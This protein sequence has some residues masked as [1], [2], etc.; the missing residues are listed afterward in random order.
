MFARARSASPTFICH[1]T[2]STVVASTLL[3]SKVVLYFDRVRQVRRL[4]HVHYHGF[5]LLRGLAFFH[6][7]QDAVQRSDPHVVLLLVY[8]FQ[9]LKFS[10]QASQVFGVLLLHVENADNFLHTLLDSRFEFGLEVV[11]H[12]GSTDVR[13]ALEAQKRSRVHASEALEQLLVAIEEI[14]VNLDFVALH[15]PLSVLLGLLDGV[16]VCVGELAHL[17]LLPAA[18]VHERDS[19]DS[20]HLHGRLVRLDPVVHVVF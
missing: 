2:L 3:L 8:W 17:V 12:E 7:F 16:K 1:P 11:L 15:K 19:Q 9:L 4:Q 13:V 14:F 20:V 6:S 10:L 5:D 18:G